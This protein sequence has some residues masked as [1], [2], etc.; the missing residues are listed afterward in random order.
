M[1][2]SV[3]CLIITTNLD[4]ISRRMRLTLSASPR[5]KIKLGPGD[6]ILIVTS[7]LSR[8]WI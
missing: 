1:G 7:L 4:L 6:W 5:D 2:M 8:I 3:G